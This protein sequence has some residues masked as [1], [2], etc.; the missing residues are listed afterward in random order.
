MDLGILFIGGDLTVAE[1]ASIASAS[2]Q[3][4]FSSLYMA[5][6]YRSAWVPMTAMAAATSNI[7]LGSYIINAYAHSPLMTALSAIDFNEYSQGRLVLGVGGGNRQINE[8]WHGIP[9]ER[10]LT[11][12]RE[13]VEILK[14][15]ANAKLGEKLVYNGKVHSMNWT[16]VTESNEKPYPVYLAAVFPKM[17]R[18]AAQ[19]A[20]GIA[21]GATISAEY[22][23]DTIKPQANKYAAETHRDPD[24]IG[25]KV[26][27]II[28][29][30]EDR[31]SARR[32]AREGIC[33]L[34][35]PLPHPYYEF[36][37]RE[38]GFGLVA[39]RL[40]ELMPQGR[41]EE[42][43]QVIPDECVDRLTI[44]GTVSDCH[45]RLQEYE[46]IVDEVLL[47]NLSKSPDNDQKKAYAGL[48]ELAKL[49]Q[50]A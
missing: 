32:S 39:D 45:S 38:Q 35:A 29:V 20:D 27:A 40:M 4:G 16:A 2:E 15:V 8:E 6:A 31:E 43:I 23:Q 10:V 46:N 44:A 19:T 50:S 36:T 28:A 7:K 30:D 37:M 33:S 1:Q 9:H 13:Y 34:Y 26:G 24:T 41:L 48:M 14:S 18:V 47:L 12:M 11:K 49:Y 17:M 21:A 22:M 5:E 25:W 3:S 42:S